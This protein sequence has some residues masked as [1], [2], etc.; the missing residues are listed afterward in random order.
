M[1]Y[2]QTFG[3][4]AEIFGR[5]DFLKGLFLKGN[6]GIGWMSGGNLQDEDFP[7]AI[8]PYS[9]TNSNMRDGKLGYATVDFGYNFFG[10]S[11]Y[12]VGGF[13]G[14]FH[15]Y[16]KFNGY[17]CTQTATNPFVCFSAIPDSVRVLTE[18]A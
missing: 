5:V 3:N 9:S 8:I 12:R 16:E 17:G 7:P 6:A 10:G 14:Y 15:Q 11:T 13:V 2:D 1:T 18:T 4:S